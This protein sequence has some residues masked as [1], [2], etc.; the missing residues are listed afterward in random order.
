MGAAVAVLQHFFGDVPVPAYTSPGK[1]G[2]VR[3]VPALSALVAEMWD[4]RVFGGMHFRN[5]NHVGA[6]LGRQTA[7]LVIA[8]F[9]VKAD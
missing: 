9:G 5:S 1:P 4:A 6:D 8:K 3:S 7:E 2:Q